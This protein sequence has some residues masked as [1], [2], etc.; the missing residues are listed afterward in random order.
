MAGNRIAQLA[1]KPGWR[2]ARRGA[3]RSGFTLLELLVVIAILGMVAAITLPAV[4]GIGRTAAINAATRQILDDVAAARQAA[5]STRSDV[6]VVFVPPY[7]QWRTNE[8]GTAP[9]NWALMPVNERRIATNLLAGQCISYA[10]FA[11]R[12]VGDQPG[13]SHPRYLSPWRTLPK[14]TFFALQQFQNIEMRIQTDAGVLRVQ[15]FE[16]QPFPFPTASSRT[17]VWLPCIGFDSMGR[18]K[19]LRG[20]SWAALDYEAIALAQGSVMPLRDPNGALRLADADVL[21]TPPGNV[22]NS[23][24]VL[25]IDWLTG[26]GRIERRQVR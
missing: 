19:N 1:R 18:L 22:T 2:A 16:R 24:N 11:A 14:G 23:F 26:R 25:V 17:T 3:G 6:Y 20:Q 5:I 15:P 8:M 7:S 10:V 4:K 21:E 13:Q 9:L 12:Q